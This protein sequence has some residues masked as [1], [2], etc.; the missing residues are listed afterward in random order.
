MGPLFS[1]FNQQ[2]TQTALPLGRPDKK[3]HITVAQAYKA[4]SRP[5]LIC[6][7][8]CCSSLVNS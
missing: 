1:F 5:R 8:P 7:T 3:P 2:G 4:R 6:W